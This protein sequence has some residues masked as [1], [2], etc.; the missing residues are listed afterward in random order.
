MAEEKRDKR[1]YHKDPGVEKK[2][3]EKVKEELLKEY[4]NVR[5]KVHTLGRNMAQS[6]GYRKSS[7]KDEEKG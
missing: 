4:E 6:T 5:F 1:P 7:G 2:A 3:R